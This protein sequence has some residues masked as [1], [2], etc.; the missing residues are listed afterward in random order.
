MEGLDLVGWDQ[1]GNPISTT[2]ALAK[3]EVPEL[4]GITVESG[5]ITLDPGDML[6]PVNP[7]ATPIPIPVIKEMC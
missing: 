7:E 4:I 5:E 6:N 1:D 2:I 3:N